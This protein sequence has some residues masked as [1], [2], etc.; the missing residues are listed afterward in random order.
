[1]LRRSR[2]YQNILLFTVTKTKQKTSTK[3]YLS[4]SLDFISVLARLLLALSFKTSLFTTVLLSWTSTEYLTK[5]ISVQN[6]R[7]TSTS[8]K[9]TWPLRH[10]LVCF[11]KRSVVREQGVSLELKN[12]LHRKAPRLFYLVLFRQHF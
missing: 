7:A 10:W 11:Y 1:M 5:T 6:R 3:L 8:V 4:S 2:T 9:N 12:L